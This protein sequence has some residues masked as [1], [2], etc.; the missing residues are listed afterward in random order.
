LSPAG[1][2]LL[3]EE[4]FASRPLDD[5]LREKSEKRFREVSAYALSE[6]RPSK[7]QVRRDF[8]RAMTVKDGI[9]LDDVPQ[10]TFKQQRGYVQAEATFSFSGDPALFDAMLDRPADRALRGT[11]DGSRLLLVIRSDEADLPMVPYALAS[12]IIAIREML[13]AQSAT[14]DRHNQAQAKDMASFVDQRWEALRLMR[15]Y[16]KRTAAEQTARAREELRAVE[17]VLS[18]KPFEF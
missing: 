4:L 1:F 12:E 15:P 10:V 9:T 14:I 3:G 2:G 5:L 6:R 17:A 16:A 18:D 11:T 13:A 7:L 8:T